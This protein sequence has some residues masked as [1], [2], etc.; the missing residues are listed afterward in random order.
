MWILQL[1]FSIL[2]I[3]FVIA[4]YRYNKDKVNEKKKLI[5]KFVQK[6][7]NSLDKG[8]DGHS[9]EDFS[10]YSKIMG[11]YRHKLGR[12]P[13][14]DELFRCFDKIKANEI[15]YESINESMDKKGEDYNTILFPEL[16]YT[17]DEVE[18]EEED[19]ISKEA[20]YEDETLVS[21]EQEKPM[22]IGVSEENEKGINN[23]YILHRPTIYNISNKIVED[24]D[25]STEKFM[26]AV[27]EKVK[28]LDNDDDSELDMDEQEE[29]QPTVE[30]VESKTHKNRCGTK[31][32][33]DAENALA[34]KKEARNMEELEMGCKRSTKKE[35]LAHE[36][37]D[38]VLR[39]DQL[40]KMPERR[41]PVCKM[42]SK[43]KCSVNP[44]EVQ[45]SL[46]GTLLDD[47][48][49]TK[50]GSILPKFTYKEK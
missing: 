10:V 39:H 45:S 25:F 47:S 37:D 5:E 33:R 15:T 32:E 19:N 20:E 43:K 44:I 9:K 24:Q 11:I 16:S 49:D 17:L 22:K 12:S 26:K 14:Q 1:L 13:T 27:K 40:W 23:Q 8:P 48:K 50:V 18:T 42:N 46:L 3:W 7:D 31:E 28:S 35:R 30:S 34:I 4:L 29:K 41:P 6:Y 38:M 36:Y 21:E 2:L